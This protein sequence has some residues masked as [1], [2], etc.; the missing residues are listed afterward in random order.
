M[1]Y[2]PPIS[3]RQQIV[4][5]AGCLF[6]EKGYKATS[7]RDIAVQVD[8]EAASLYNHIKSK[9]DILSDLLFY[10]A[11]RFQ[12]GMKEI[13][14]SS[15]S[16]LEKIKALIVLHIKLTTEDTHAIG[17]LTR[18]WRHLKEPELSNFVAIRNSYSEDFLALINAGMKEGA[19]K[20][21]NSEIVL[22][23]IFSSLSWLYVW[24]TT[25]KNISPEELEVQITDLLVNGIK[26]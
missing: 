9:H 4:Y 26:H 14:E 15:S 3:R 1:E 23:T 21:A 6:R 25:D 17:L 13:N 2:V 19:I 20:K 8:M 18:D 10:I 12:R 16:S 11:R 24:Y 22:N 7:M 5:E